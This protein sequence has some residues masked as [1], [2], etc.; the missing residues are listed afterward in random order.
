MSTRHVSRIQSCTVYKP[1]NPRNL[2]MAALLWL[3]LDFKKMLK[4]T[5]GWAPEA[6]PL[7]A[8][9]FSRNVVLIFS[10]EVG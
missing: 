6:T 7:R 2:Q 1:P 4:L 5:S 9:E 3:F 8:A 10:P